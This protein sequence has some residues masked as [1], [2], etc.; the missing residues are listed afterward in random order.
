MVFWKLELFRKGF[1]DDIM[2]LTFTLAMIMMAL[3]MTM[4]IG[5]DFDDAEDDDCVC[6]SWCSCHRSRRMQAKK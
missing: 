2:S 5:G 4:M 3:M 1:D 6:R